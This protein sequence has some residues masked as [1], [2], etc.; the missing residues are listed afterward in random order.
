MGVTRD[1][2]GLASDDADVTG[3]VDLGAVIARI[4]RLVERTF[5]VRGVRLE[6]ACG[7]GALPLLHGNEKALE[8]AC[9]N[10]VLNA[11]DATPAG[12]TVRVEARVA[13]GGA[14]LELEVRDTGAGVPAELRERIFEPFFTT[15][16]PRGGTGLGLAVCRTVVERH[17]G[18][19]RLEV[20]EG[21]GSRFV[22]ALPVA[23]GVPA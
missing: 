10:L 17:G 21:G 22:L 3:V 15:K 1:L 13:R 12:G 19:I 16:G 7:D 14:E 11:A 23:A 2:L 6:A 5:T 20:G 8:T 4:A 9:L 18:S